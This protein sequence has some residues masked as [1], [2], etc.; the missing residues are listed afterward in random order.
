MLLGKK[1]IKSVTEWKVD[2]EIHFNCHSQIT[3]A[4]AEK[5]FKLIFMLI[6][7]IDELPF[8][9]HPDRNVQ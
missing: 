5:Y 6:F 3:V 7:D 2:P 8:V 1:R 4:T 9:L